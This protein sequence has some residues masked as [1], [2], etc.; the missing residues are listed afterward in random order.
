[1]CFLP[2]PY[3]LKPAS[4]LSL[5]QLLLSFSFVSKSCLRTPARIWR[6]SVVM[7]VL[8]SNTPSPSST[9]AS[10]LH[11]S[12]PQS[13]LWKDPTARLPQHRSPSRID[14]RKSRCV[15]N[16]SD[17]LGTFFLSATTQLLKSAFQSVNYSP[18]K[19]LEANT[20]RNSIMS[21]KNFVF[22]IFR[23]AICILFS[24]IFL[25]IF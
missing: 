5:I 1:M 4:P 14:C 23:N 17:S 2:A 16:Y 25:R 19:L 20:Q 18:L 8:Q 24:F 22:D 10:A 11:G 15:K 13:L 7:R 9:P 21:R 12:S 6:S 3:W